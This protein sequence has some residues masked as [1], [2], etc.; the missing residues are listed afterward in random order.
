MKQ[1]VRTYFHFKE[2]TIDTIKIYAI[3]LVELCAVPDVY[4]EVPSFSKDFLF[5][6]SGDDGGSTMAVNGNALGGSKVVEAGEVFGS[7]VIGFVEDVFGIFEVVMCFSVGGV[8]ELIEVG[9]V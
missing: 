3:I 8:V 7:K 1:S 2:I 4:R 5:A 6:L 9:S